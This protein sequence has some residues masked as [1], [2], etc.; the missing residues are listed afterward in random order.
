MSGRL[1]Y[2]AASTAAIGHD[3]PRSQQWGSPDGEPEDGWYLGAMPVRLMPDIL[4]PL[5]RGSPE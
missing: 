5:T 1:R 2:G 3:Q 4:L